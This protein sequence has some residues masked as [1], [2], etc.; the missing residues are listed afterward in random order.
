MGENSKGLSSSLF[1]VINAKGGESIKPKAKGPHHHF[2]KFQKIKEETISIGIS[3]GFKISISIKKFNWYN[4]IYFKN[5]NPFKNPLESYRENFFRGSFYL[6]KGKAFETG[7]EFQIL[8]MLLEIIFLYLWLFA[9]E[10]EKDFPKRFAKISKWCKYGL[11][12]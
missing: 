5:G 12:C 1:L 11:K 4:F 10:F 7:G 9:K 2:K 6:V 3:F 8:K